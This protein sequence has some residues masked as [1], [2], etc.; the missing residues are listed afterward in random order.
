MI[1]AYKYVFYKLC[2]FERMIFDPVPGLTAFGFLLVLQF[3]N[4]FSLYLVL[5][6]F[7]EFSLPFRWSAS[8]FA[9]A[10]ALFA[11]PQ[12]FLLLHGDRFKRVVQEFGHEGERQ[13]VIGG[14]IVGA[15]VVF[16]FVFFFWAASLPPRNL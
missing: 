14:L 3:F 13:N 6:R 2:L 1:R 12:Y 5:R 9:C 15:Y 10:I 11:V 7:F 8:N 4:L 16:S